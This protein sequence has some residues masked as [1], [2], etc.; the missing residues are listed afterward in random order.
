MNFEQVRQEFEVQD[1]IR[2]KKAKIEGGVN[3]K[4]RDLI[5]QSREY[6]EE[7]INSP[8]GQENYQAIESFAGDLDLDPEEVREE[9][10]KGLR[11]NIKAAYKAELIDEE[12]QRNDLE[13]IIG[14]YTLNF[15]STLSRFKKDKDRGRNEKPRTI[16]T[17][18][19][20]MYLLPP[21][22]LNDL[23]KSYQDNPDVEDWMIKYATLN[24]SK[25][26]KEA[27][28][29]SLEDIGNLRQKYQKNPD[30]EDWMIK[31]L[32][33]SNSADPQSAIEA[34]LTSIKKL[35]DKYKGNS[36]VSN[37]M[38]KTFVIRE[39]DPQEAIEEALVSVAKLKKDY[40]G[41]PDVEDWMI[42]HFV[43]NN[44]KDPQAALD[45]ALETMKAL[46]KKF[47][48]RPEVNGRLTR[49][50]AVHN[51]DDAEAALA[52]ALENKQVVL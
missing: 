34:V 31:R 2:D 21:D 50:F 9:F 28:N 46:R 29:R 30:V 51:P 48:N 36:D 41:N 33:F 37:G 24:N 7:L 39:A 35:K 18:A 52:R 26:P 40:K 17:I 20:K 23:R 6:L 1:N 42:H 49:H 5:D 15:R 27:I 8:Y 4:L 19:K 32:V 14:A 25:D 12:S 16:L 38:I 43:T 11:Y 13:A 47:K 44:S 45:K 22:I 3:P 10:E